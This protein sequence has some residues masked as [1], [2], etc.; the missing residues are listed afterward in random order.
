MCLAHSGS[1]PEWSVDGR[2][3][4][5]SI[6][7]LCRMHSN[8]FSAFKINVPVNCSRLQSIQ[9]ILHAHRHTIHTRTS[10]PDYIHQQ[11]RYLSRLRHSRRL[12]TGFTFAR[13]FSFT[14]S[15]EMS[16]L[17]FTSC[18]PPIIAV[19]FLGQQL[20]MRYRV[21][22]V[23]SVVRGFPSRA[24][25]CCTKNSPSSPL[26]ASPVTGFLNVFTT[27]SCGLPLQAPSD[28]SRVECCFLSAS[29]FRRGRRVVS[30]SS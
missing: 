17:P 25:Q 15:A 18:V 7:L 26:S 21:L 5:H 10:L 29:I 9:F 23:W 30:A 12:L 3:G 24:F 1:P 19:S 27:A 14:C 16:V 22:S 20:P 4:N 2:L 6:A 8:T 11:I 13:Y 28:S